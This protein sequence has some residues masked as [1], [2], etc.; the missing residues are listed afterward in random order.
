M[1]NSG[2]VFLVIAAHH[3]FLTKSISSFETEKELF[4]L[5]GIFGW[6]ANNLYCNIIIIINYYDYYWS[7]F[8]ATKYRSWLSHYSQPCLKHILEDKYY[9]HYGFLVGGIF[10]LSRRTIS[11]MERMRNAQKLD[12]LHHIYAKVVNPFIFQSSGGVKF[13]I[14]LTVLWL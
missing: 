1:W 13:I 10:L 5:S 2:K 6:K 11:N 9:Q 4:N 14:L 12:C 7:Q 8:A 3:N